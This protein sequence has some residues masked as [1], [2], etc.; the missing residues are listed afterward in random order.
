MP[1]VDSSVGAPV[2]LDQDGLA[3]M[4][5]AL[6][7]KGYRVIGPRA[8]DGAIIYDDIA[9]IDDLP[10]GLGDERSGGR[11]RLRPRGDDALFGYTTAPQG[12][13]RFLYPPRQR[14][15]A[16]RRTGDGF[17]IEPPESAPPPMAFIGVRACELAAIALQARVF[18]DKDFA[19]PGY[20]HRLATAFVVAVECSESGGDCFCASMASGP[21]VA[22]DYDIRLIELK[23]RRYVADA[24]SERGR[25][26]LEAL[27]SAQPSA[28]D[29]KAVAAAR[30]QARATQSK[31]MDTGTAANLKSW[32]EHARWDHVAARCLTCGNC[33]MVCPTCFCTTVEDVTDLRGDHAERWRKWDS[34]FSLEFSYIHGGAVRTEA[35]SRY[36]QWITHKLST[37]NDQ[38]GS[39]GCVGCG[40]CITWCPVGI[41]ITEEVD[42]IAA[43]QGDKKGRS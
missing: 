43:A 11:Y 37:W 9:G 42:A 36:R 27:P 16:A 26:V 7:A 6:T 35:R 29:T 2:V 39:S 31:T 5:A 14:M 23:G 12:W 20:R 38:F 30:K 32:P 19:D 15:F 34:C 21:E 25:E 13:K 28:A 4:I 18:G 8:A 1:G 41:D 24:A 3:R 22:G 33:T 10:A 17:A 40:R